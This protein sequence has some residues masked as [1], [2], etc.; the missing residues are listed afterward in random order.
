MLKT[1]S[2][3]SGILCIALSML[4]PSTLAHESKPE[5]SAQLLLMGTFHFANTTDYAAVIMDDWDS[6]NRQQQIIEVVDE[7][8]RF[9]PTKV[10]I[11]RP[12]S[13]NQRYADEYASYLKGE[14]EMPANEM[15]QLGFRVAKRLEL[16][17]PEGIDF[18]LSLDEAPL[19][20][21]LEAHQAMDA[22]QAIIA[23]AQAGAKRST[24]KLK[25]QHLINVLNDTNTQDYLYFNKNLYT[26][27]V[28][29]LTPEAHE[30]GTDFV[31]SWWKRNFRI[32]Q[33]I[34]AYLQPNERVLVIIG[35][36]H[37]ALL[38][39]FYESTTKIE[40]VPALEYLPLKP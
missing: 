15:Y 20:K 21:Y 32:K 2:F 13:E 35:A 12:A 36:G 17:A 33:N 14:F 11:E 22:F 16:S 26:E 23:S 25:Q 10:L 3:A 30:V 34:D 1:V 18:H 8:V 5:E 27:H 24:E 9:K 6:P 31:S 38:D 37:K 39:D 7:L 4:S 29:N 40:Y 28:L 19:I